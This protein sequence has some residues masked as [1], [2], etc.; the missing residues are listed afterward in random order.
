[1]SDLHIDMNAKCIAQPK[2]F[3]ED[4]ILHHL[5]ET[6]NDYD[7]LVI[8]GD[9]NKGMYYSI[10][11]LDKIDKVL[12]ENSTITTVI[13]IKF[14]VG[15]H[16]VVATEYH[17]VDEGYRYYL[18]SK[19]SL[20][21]PFHLT[22]KTVLVGSLGW[23]DYSYAIEDGFSYEECYHF[24][25]NHYGL[26]TETPEEIFF[27]E[28]DTLICQKENRKYEQ[29]LK[30]FTRQGKDIFLVNHFVPFKNYIM[31]KEHNEVNYNW[32]IS[33]AFM[34]SKDLEAIINR[35]RN[36]KYVAF[37]HTHTRKFIVEN[38]EFARKEILVPLGRYNE[39]GKDDASKLTIEE[40]T[41]LYVDE[42]QL[43]NV[44]ITVN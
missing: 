22:E 17:T 2:E 16:D 37:G 11:F 10:D 36:V 40:L 29:W 15:N 9:I 33:N 12:N 25:M 39:W 38:K 1:M 41:Q 4:I 7:F 21:Q 26:P 31:Y 20:A 30:E 8:V 42:L 44:I 18:N 43:L 3:L 14:V 27:S 28:D 6:K 32:N 13:P 34:G 5:V 24:R 35:Y 19:Y 23:I